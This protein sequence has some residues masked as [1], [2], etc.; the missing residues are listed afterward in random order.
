MLIFVQA[1]CSRPRKAF[2]NCTADKSSET[3]CELPSQGL[4]YLVVLTSLQNRIRVVCIHYI[5]LQILKET[6]AHLDHTWGV[7][8]S[9]LD[10]CHW[11]I[12]PT[13]PEQAET[14]SPASRK[15]TTHLQK[16]RK[17]PQSIGGIPS[18]FTPSS[19]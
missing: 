8:P 15:L 10:V 17:R 16:W 2:E 14:G 1:L 3:P 19:S 12:L 4:L 7:V 13:K 11:S 6:E 18:A 5:S 9:S